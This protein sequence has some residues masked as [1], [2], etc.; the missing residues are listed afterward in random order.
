VDPQSA[1]DQ[2]PAYAPNAGPGHHPEVFVA[3]GIC[4][5]L[6]CSPTDVPSKGS[7]NPSVPADWPGGFFCPCHGSTFD[8]PAGCSRTSRHRPTWRSRRTAM[9]ATQLLIGESTAA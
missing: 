5:H 4:T 1:K 3:I 9:S 6:G 7:N 8:G 2:Q